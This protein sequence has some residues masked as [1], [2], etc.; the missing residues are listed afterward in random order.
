MKR[1]G[2]NILLIEA[3]IMTA[4]LSAALSICLTVFSSAS[5]MRR[6][7][8]ELSRASSLVFS[9]AQC[10]ISTGD[11]AAVSTLMGGD[12]GDIDI[13]DIVLSFER[14]GDELIITAS[15]EGRVIISQRA[16][17]GVRP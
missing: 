7:A 17:Q 14:D 2:S 9:A 6:E 3:I 1:A 13:D 5:D 12:G 8:D 15:R 16:T 11:E 10:Y 4:V